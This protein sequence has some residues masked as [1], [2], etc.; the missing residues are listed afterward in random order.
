MGKRKLQIVVIVVLAIGLLSMLVYWSQ[1]EQKHA[2]SLQDLNETYSEYDK[3]IRSIRD[4]MERK[5]READSIEQSAYVILAFSEENNLL[6]DEIFPLLEKK[7]MQAT[8][9]LKNGAKHNEKLAEVLNEEGWDIA[10]GGEIG[11]NKEQ[12]IKDLRNASEKYEK[13]T[14]KTAKAYFFNG[15]EYGTGSG[16]LYPAFVDMPFEISVAFSKNNDILNHGINQDYGKEIEE[17]QNVSMREDIEVMK[18]IL[19]QVAE[20][21]SVV[22]LSD[23]GSDNQM[24]IAEEEPLENLNEILDFLGEKQAEEKFMVG[25]VSQYLEALENKEKLREERQKEYLEY[26]EQCKEKIKEL[27]KERDEFLGR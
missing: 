9:V 7:E 21:K 10:F 27:T 13:S 6:L 15:K 24:E 25:S 19:E 3:K 26:E 11:E 2:A 5:R 14:G 12:Y 18:N 20:K 22:V 4:D 1:R 17:C 8:L 16:E 23:F